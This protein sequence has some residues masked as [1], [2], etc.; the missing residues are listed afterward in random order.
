MQGKR[1]L[2]FLKAIFART[3]IDRARRNHGLEHA[4]VTV[5]TEKIKGLRLSGRA[6]SRGFFIYGNVDTDE[7]RN[8]AQ[9]AL[10]RMRN[11]EAHLAIHPNCGTSLVAKGMAAALAAYV[12]FIGASTLMGRWRR[13]PQ[14]TLLSTL[15]V[16]AGH[17]IGMFLQEHITTSAEVRDMRIAGIQ[18]IESNN[19]V[20]H[21]VR[22]EG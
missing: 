14:V 2:T 18:R 19:S 1:I 20:R 21:F 16:V 7:L 22:T 9:E 11:G 13:L 15:A 5:L 6:T 3:P 17:P 4:T 8:A 10:Q 12:G